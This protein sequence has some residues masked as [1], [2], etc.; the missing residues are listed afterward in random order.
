MIKGLLT[1]DLAEKY[2]FI[3]ASSHVDGSKP[4]KLLQAITGIIKTAYYLCFSR[5]DLVYIHCGDIVSVKRKYYYMWLC[6]LFGKRVVLHFHGASFV[7]QYYQASESWQKRIARFL[8]WPQRTICLSR[9]WEKALHKINNESRTVVIPNAIHIPESIPDRVGGDSF[10]LLFLGAIGER[11]GV[12][13][14][15]RAIRQLRDKGCSLT[16]YVGGNGDVGTLEEQITNLNLHDCVK[17][18]GWVGPQ[19]RHDLFEQVDCFVLP[20]YGEGMPMSILEA[21]SFG[22][23]VISTRVGG[24][25][26]L[27]KDGESGFLGEP[28]DISFF[29]EKIELLMNSSDSAKSM[30][31]VAR[32]TVKKDH[33]L[34]LYAIRI[35]DLFESVLHEV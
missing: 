27:I 25:P 24:I 14:L 17:Y 7:D 26:E 13:D 12:Y 11:K 23:P 35:S 19:Q 9:S 20:S 30:G 29:A 10:A 6:N 4:K 32:N 18:L 5:V 2:S 1:S 34:K 22:L 15:V 31:L 33:D 8:E 21:M 28:G 16:L 3:R